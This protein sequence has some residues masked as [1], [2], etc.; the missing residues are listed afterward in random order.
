M[1]GRSRIAWN[2]R[3][4]RTAKRISQETLALDAEVDRGTISEIE[5]HKFNPTV[6]LLDRLASA[7]AVDVAEFLLIPPDG[8]DSP[9]SLRAGRKAGK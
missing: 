3:R 2:L 6:D 5:T 4:I 8:S 1:D 7:L 9:K